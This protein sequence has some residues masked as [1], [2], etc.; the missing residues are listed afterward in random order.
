MKTDKKTLQAP[1]EWFDWSFFVIVTKDLVILYVRPLYKKI[2]HVKNLVLLAMG[3]AEA[4]VDSSTAGP[5]L[6]NG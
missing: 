5:E 3:V 2:Q 6:E 1:N 4:Q